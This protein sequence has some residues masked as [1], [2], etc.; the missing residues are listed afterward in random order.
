MLM[1]SMMKKDGND[2]MIVTDSDINK[3]LSY[4]EI[5]IAVK[6]ISPKNRFLLWKIS[7]GK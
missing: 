3:T 5:I 4:A 6:T 2:F 1:L 7:M